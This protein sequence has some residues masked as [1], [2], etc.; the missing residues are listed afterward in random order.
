MIQDKFSHLNVSRQRRYQLRKAAKGLCSEC[1]T[2]PRGESKSRCV[3]CL[4]KAR[5]RQRRLKKLRRRYR[6]SLSY[7]MEAA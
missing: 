2:E 3:A 6:G 7:K 5:E 4:V 1:G